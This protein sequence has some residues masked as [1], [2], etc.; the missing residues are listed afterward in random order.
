MIVYSRDALAGPLEK[1]RRIMK[2]VKKGRFNPDQTRSG[3]WT[4]KIKYRHKDSTVCASCEE[5]V[6]AGEQSD[7]DPLTW[8]HRCGLSVHNQE[9]CILEC[10]ACA[11]QLCTQCRPPEE[12]DCTN[13]LVGEGQPTDNEAVSEGSDQEDIEVNAEEEAVAELQTVPKDNQIPV[14]VEGLVRNGK[15]GCIHKCGCLIDV[16]GC[17]I[18]IS[19]AKFYP[20]EEWPDDPWPICRKF[21]C[22]AGEA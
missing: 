9:P 22:F 14:P 12:H 1:L 15:K 11:L 7:S 8:C 18:T 16:T 6:G 5:A 2:L 13:T 4:K 19:M 20:M 3:R 10:K 17:G 21:G